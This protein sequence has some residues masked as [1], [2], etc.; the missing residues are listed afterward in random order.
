MAWRNHTLMQPYGSAANADAYNLF[1]A[2]QPTHNGV[3]GGVWDYQNVEWEVSDNGPGQP[4][5]LDTLTVQQTVSFV[6]PF[7]FGQ[8]FDLGL[9][10]MA[11]VGQT[12][13]GGYPHTSGSR[14]IGWAGAGQVLVGGALLPQFALASASGIDYT[15]PL[16]AAAVPEPASFALLL[17]GL[18]ALGGLASRTQDRRARRSC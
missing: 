18:L 13:Q 17:A 3:V 9:Y 12:A 15:Q 11:T 16:A 2:Q 1:L 4:N 6:V 10:A 5:R 7:T 14:G 8:A